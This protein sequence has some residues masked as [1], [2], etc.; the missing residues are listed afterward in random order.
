MKSTSKQ[1]SLTIYLLCL[2]NLLQADSVAVFQIAFPLWTIFSADTIFLLISLYLSIYL[3]F[4]F[5]WWAAASLLN[6]PPVLLLEWKSWLEVEGMTNEMR[7]LGNGCLAY[8][9]CFLSIKQISSHW[10]AFQGREENLLLFPEENISQIITLPAS[11]QQMN[12]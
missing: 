2:I 6:K 10:T 1:S 11:Q 4:S 5:Q 9:V 3:P 7:S 12:I 8:V